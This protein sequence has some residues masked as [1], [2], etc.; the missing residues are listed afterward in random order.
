MRIVLLVVFLFISASAF[1]EEPPKTPEVKS[2]QQTEGGV[3]RENN[4]SHQQKPPAPSIA[5]I[6]NTDAEAAEN[7][8]GHKTHNGGQEGA[9]FWT[10]KGYSLK[11]TDTLLVLFTFLLFL[12]TV[13]LWWSTRRLVKGADETAKTQL[14]PYVF[15]QN[16]E[17]FWTAEKATELIVKW[18][19]FPVW[20]NS[21]NTWT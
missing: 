8:S 13:A 21:G 1:S 7:K 4:S 3:Q 10:A 16:V 18:T 6:P 11:I 14:R 17:F 5:V 9:E 12:A 2:E 20:K 15:V 19:F